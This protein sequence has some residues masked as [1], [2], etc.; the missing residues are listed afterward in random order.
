MK[1][2]PQDYITPPPPRRQK[3]EWKTSEIR[4]IGELYGTM[5][6]PQIAPLF[7]TTVSAIYN[8]AHKQGW[9]SDRAKLLQKHDHR[10]IGSLIEIGLSSGEIE[11]QT[12]IN[13]RHI[14]W[15][16]KNKLSE[17]KSEKLAANGRRAMRE[18]NNPKQR[19]QIQSQ[20]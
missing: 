4:A 10:L 14:L 3:R 12:G 9:R 15:V 18:N 17:E 16:T 8:M 5:P 2:L 13:Q 20:A 6:V 11:Q 7:D 1:L 19:Q